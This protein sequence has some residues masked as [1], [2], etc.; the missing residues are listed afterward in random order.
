[1]THAVI[2]DRASTKL[3]KDNYS[4]VNA[5]DV[6][7][8]IAEQNGFSYEYIKEIGS[9][10][11]LTGRPEM[12]K[13]L[14]RIAAGEIQAIIVQDLDRLARPEEAV[15]YTTIRGVIMQYNVI[16]YTH[17]SRVDL[18]NDDDDFVADITMSVAKKERRRILKRMRRS[19]KTKAEQGRYIGGSAA[20]GYK[21]VYRDGKDSDLAIDESEVERVKVIFDT[22]EASGGNLGSSARML[23]EQGYIGKRGK[24]FHPNSLRS[25]AAN[26]LY[27]GIF[28]TA[29]TDKVSH[30][31]DLRIISLDQFERVQA[32]IK[33]R[34]GHKRDLGR[35]GQ[36]IF[37]GFVVCGN[38]GGTMV[39]SN[40]KD[41]TCVVYQCV[42]RRKYSGCTAGKSYKEL[43]ILAPIVEFLADFIQSQ[44]DFHA[45][46]DAKAAQFGKSI[47]EEALEAA[48]HGEL[49]S[50][51]AG[52]E[53]IIEA[54]SLGILSTQ[55]AAAKLAELREQ[56]QRL[57][58]EL[59]SIAE[60]TE[61]MA[62]W[63]EALEALK[64]QDISSRLYD[65][66]SEKPI[67][68]RRLLSIVF[69][70]NS[71]RVR[72]E[73]VSGYTWRGVLESYKLTETMQTK[74]VSFDSELSGLLTK[75]A[76]LLELA[77]LISYSPY[78]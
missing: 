1:M 34:T 54:I 56:E 59:F 37:T 49:A 32:L 64:G 50:V 7:I 20:L 60:K 9:G 35:R 25:L 21:V 53:R 46:L 31:P 26:K 78:S 58:V 69:E 12:M 63:Q 73:H 13:I 22:L 41:R 65:L 44:I 15:V 2:Y 70:P 6:G 40:K 18:N 28:E 23:N 75:D 36:Y 57:T 48:V 33:N 47:T 4:R 19:V 67:A 38:C 14:D 11:T 3:Q 43:L 10:T 17:T 42:N 5:H 55:E 24:L 52:K 51:K 39:A 76:P 61:I 66:A 8:R 30:R 27:I 77:E 72:T 29:V 71:L 45:A 68:F 16:I 62:Q 74:E